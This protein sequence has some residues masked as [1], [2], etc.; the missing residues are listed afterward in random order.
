MK[1]AAIPGNQRPTV[2]SFCFSPLASWEMRKAIPHILPIQTEVQIWVLYTWNIWGQI[3]FRI[4][5]ILGFRKAVSTYAAYFITHPAGCVAVPRFILSWVLKTVN[6][7]VTVQV[8]ICLQMNFGIFPPPKKR[9]LK[10]YF[11]ELLD[12]GII[13]KGVGTCMWR[14]PKSYLSFGVKI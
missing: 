11:L 8:R 14:I 3:C 12:F 13:N 2:Y 1:I 9:S 7:L 6:S 5:N 4:Q 10:F